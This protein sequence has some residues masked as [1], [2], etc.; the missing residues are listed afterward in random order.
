MINKFKNKKKGF[1]LVELIIAISL[2]TIIAF[3]SIGAVLSIFDANR[4]ARSSKTIV[5]NLNLSLESMVRTIRFGTNYHCGGSGDLSVPNDCSSGDVSF[6]V[7]FY[8]DT[9]G[10]DVIVTYSIDTDGSL[11]NRQ[12]DGE[13]SSITSPEAKIEYLRFYVF[14]SEDNGVNQPYVIAVIKGHSG[15]KQSSQTNFSV[16]TLISQRALDL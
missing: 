8:D 3:F 4:K 16:Q 2:F 11:I 5:D 10:R 7:T 6:S 13:G 12:Y 1:T 15:N 9:L 14:N